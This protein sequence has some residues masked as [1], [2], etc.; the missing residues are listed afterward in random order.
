MLKSAVILL[1]PLAL[2]VQT[3]QD[4][5]RYAPAEGTTINRSY[6]LTMNT[7]IDES[8]TLMNG[9]DSMSP[10]IEGS[11]VY[12]RNVVVND[13]LRKMAAGQPAALRRSFEELTADVK[14][15][16]KVAA[17]GMNVDADIHY[18]GSSGLAGKQVDFIW[19]ADAGEYEKSH[20]EEGA[21]AELLAGLIEDMDMRA[22]LPSAGDVAPGDSWDVDPAAFVDVLFLGGDLAFDLE[23]IGDDPPMGMG[24]IGDQPS[25][26]DLWQDLGECDVTATLG[27]PRTEGDSQLAVITIQ[28]ELE[29]LADMVDL[30]AQAVEKAVPDGTQVDIS[31][32]T[33]E[34]F[35]EGKGVLLW[36]VAAGRAHSLEFSGEFSSTERQEMSISIGGNDLEVESETTSSGKADLTI[37]FE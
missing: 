15:P 3:P 27:E 28:V 19:D 2:Q 10:S 35:L 6:S 20:V 14:S 1:T 21:D 29:S 9:D 25:P 12:T 8:K 23:S 11:T 16:V 17:P 13:E 22:L 4:A 7:V 36:N 5:L 32:A 31:T 26:R 18:T 30:V 24:E 37:R 33:N 34:S